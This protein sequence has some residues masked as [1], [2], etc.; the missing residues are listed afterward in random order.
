MSAIAGMAVGIAVAGCSL[1]GAISLTPL[2]V[3][4]FG[5]LVVLAV[6]GLAMVERVQRRIY[7]ASGWREC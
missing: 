7:A 1:G 3:A 2:P 4:V 5:A 6:G